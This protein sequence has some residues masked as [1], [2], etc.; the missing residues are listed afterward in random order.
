V[1]IY[2]DTTGVWFNTL[3]LTSPLIT[4]Y[5]NSTFTTTVNN[6]LSATNSLGAALVSGRTYFA[7]VKISYGGLS[8]NTNLY[9]GD[10]TFTVT[11]TQEL[12]SE[13]MT[14]ASTQAT[15]QSS[16]VSAQSSIESKVSAVKSDTALILTATQTT[17][18]AAVQTVT[19]VVKSQILN[20]ENTVRSGQTLTVRYRTYSGLA[21]TLNVYDAT[22]TQRLS[23]AAMKEIGNT[24]IYE[25]NVTFLTAWGKGDF[26]VACSEPT[27]GTSDA[28]TITVLNTDIEQVSGQVS[29]ILGSTAGISG[30]NTLADTLSSQFNVIE[31]VLSQVGK[32][33]TKE[34]KDAVSSST[35]LESVSSQLNGIANKIKEITGG[36][37][38]NLDKLY[39]VSGDKK[40][41]IVYL[42]NKTQEIKAAIELNQKIVDNIANKPVTQSWYEYK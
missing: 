4:D 37:G 25:Y 7:K 18:P 39:Q 35:A 19:D 11:I 40:Q 24:G 23:K 41:D 38:I 16:I 34:V 28:L 13:I 10:T 22:D 17:I 1:Q 42:K 30:L 29:A 36:T 27:K 15:L 20:R 21:P 32:K 6:L 9:E 2:D 5:T 33:G 3:T 14:I 31:G 12:S 8:G 26:T